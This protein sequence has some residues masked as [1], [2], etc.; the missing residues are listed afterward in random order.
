MSAALDLGAV[1][2]TLQRLVERDGRPLILRD[3]ATGAEHRLPTALVAA[4]EGLMP[5]FLAAANAVWRAATGR[6]L[7]IEQA[8]DPASLLGYR[9]KGI[10]GEPFSVVMLAALEAIERTGSPAALP[11]NDFA[12]LWRQLRPAVVPAAPDAG[13]Q[14]A[15]GPAP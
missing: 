1:G 9:V 3:E 2:R 12:A 10:R 14:R 7:G 4:P 5:N 11:V 8:H 6:H 15:R 13:P